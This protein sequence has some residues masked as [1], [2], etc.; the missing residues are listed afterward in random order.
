MKPNEHSINKVKINS[1]KKTSNKNLN[2]VNEKNFTKISPTKIRP[3]T[4]M[5]RNILEKQYIINTKT[6]NCFWHAYTP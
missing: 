6:A 2:L 1:D 5:N 3:K 4:R